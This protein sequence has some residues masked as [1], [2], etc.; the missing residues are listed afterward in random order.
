MFFFITYV[1]Y[2]YSFFLLHYLLEFPYFLVVIPLWSA[3][4]SMMGEVGFVTSSVN[5][6]MLCYF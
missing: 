5:K 3:G 2:H 4:V 1:D 6:I